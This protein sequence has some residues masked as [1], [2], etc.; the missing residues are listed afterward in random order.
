MSNEK[1]FLKVIRGFENMH[2]ELT[3]DMVAGLLKENIKSKSKGIRFFRGKTNIEIV[4][5]NFQ[6]IMERTGKNKV[7]SL[8]NLLIRSGEFDATIKK[9]LEFIIEYLNRETS[10]RI[11]I[12]DFY[13]KFMWDSPGNK[14]FI[15]KNINQIIQWTG[16]ES[17]F[18]MA[19]ALKGMSPEIADKINLELEKHKIDVAKSLLEDRTQALEKVSGVSVDIDGYALTLSLI[20]DELLQS[21]NKRLI[22]INKVGAGAYSTVF[23][24][25]DKILKVGKPRKT[26]EIPNSRRILQPMLRTNFRRDNGTF[27]ATIEVSN[28]VDTKL[29]NEEKTDEKLYAL[30]KELR[31]EGIVWGDVKWENVGKLKDKNIPVLNGEEYSSAPNAIGF[32]TKNKGT[33]LGTGELV[34]LDT[35]YIFKE[36]SQ[37]IDFI[38]DSYKYEN[39]YIREK[40]QAKAKA[41]IQNV[42][43]SKQISKE[44]HE[45]IEH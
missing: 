5:D 32:E 22:D 41:R 27:F 3:Y 9:N 25:G 28:S 36:G 4:Q 7:W 42:E 38:R 26:Y 39:R 33:P 44:S 2:G 29:K 23:S 6:E 35:D 21:E 31:D 30:Y 1:T 14:R 24:V 19:L 43:K 8:L 13:R 40:M 10:T 20:I 11:Y 45:D 16:K 34:V 37:D 15:K 18:E 17:L 12:A